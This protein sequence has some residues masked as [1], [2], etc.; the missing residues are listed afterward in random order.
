MPSKTISAETGNAALDLALDTLKL[1]KQALV[2]V[3]TKKSAEKTA[4]DIARKIK[5]NSKE[6]EELSEK[7]LNALSSPTKQCQRL[8]ASIKKG[9]AFH[10]AGLVAKQR[11]LIEDNFK[12]GAIKIICSTPS[13]AMGVDLPAYRAI[14]KDLK[15]YG[16]RGMAFIP[17]L[18]YLQM[19]GRAGRPKYDTEGEAICIAISESEKDKLFEKYVLGKPEDI[20]PKLAVEP[21]LRTYLLSLIAANFVNTKKKIVDFFSRTFW[22]YQYTDM[23]RLV[24]IID[25][26]LRLL[27][28]WGFI[29]REEKKNDFVSADMINNNDND[30]N[31]TA[32]IMGKRVA[33]LYIDPLTA[34]FFITCLRSGS[35]KKIN[36]F[37]FLQMVSHTLEMMPLLRVGVKEQDKIQEE[38]MKCYELLFEKEPSLYEAEYED[39]VNSIKTALMLN[40]WIDEKTEEH[41]LENYNTRPGELRSKMDIADWLL[42]ATEEISRIL[43]FQHLNKEIVKLRLRLRYGVKEELLPLV[44][45]P[46]IGRV[47][48]RKLFFNRIK[49]VG[50]VKNADL[51]KLSQILGQQVA[52]NVKKEVGEEI[53]EV[54]L[55]KRKGQISLGDY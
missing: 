28:E 54:P 46:G 39:F 48:A 47:R 1:G 7:A 24:L 29:G 51:M 20:Y 3:N 23:D 17:V 8:A 40:E 5:T 19:A 37:S 4:E 45:I 31:I 53:K 9:V 32:T 13:L 34:Y 27:E 52:L 22:A 2:F 42:Y 12:S 50:D 33:E 21:V 18:E 26:M 43:E 10:H 35:N 11:E 55:G 16:S 49:D 41:L 38:L 30:E 25:K 44:R 15:R 14:I 36:N 6:L